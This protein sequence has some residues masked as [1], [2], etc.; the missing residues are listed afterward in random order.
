MKY[1]ITGG[2]GLV[3]SEITKLLLKNSEQINWLTSSKKENKDVNCYNW[4]IYKNQIDSACFQNVD[5]MIHL[6]GAGVADKK[7]TIE[8]KKELIESRIKSTQLLYDG[9]K[10]LNIKPKV[11]I[12]ASAIGIY[13]NEADELLNEESK[14]GNDFL[15][16]LTNKWEMAVTKFEN[17]GI[18]VVKLRIG[19]VLSKDGGYLK[20][21]SAPAKYGFA[22]AL[23]N[24]KM[25]TSWIHITDL[26]KMFLYASKNENMEGVYNAV[27]PNPVT[28]I[29]ITKQI[30]KALNR[31]YFLPN[32]PEFLLEI[33]FG[34]MAAV[35]LMSQNISSEK[36][37][38]AGFK[39]EFD[40]VKEAL[41]NIYK[42]KK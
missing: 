31:P 14:I 10:H 24:G 15:A 19:I 42:T 8:R 2:S 3:G 9:V 5:V 27:A 21:V 16:D 40:E 28:N 26:A 1:L 11:I 29:E 18:R 13:K 33:A 7:W 35:I 12:S 32:I 38:K 30:A 6:A 34:E 36:I 25:I 20:S 37:E 39:F 22:A 41:K 17:I 4:N 23:G